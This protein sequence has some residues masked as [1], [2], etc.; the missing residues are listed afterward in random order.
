MSELIFSN[1]G[2]LTK[3]YNYEIYTKHPFTGESGWDIKFISVKADCK[4]EADKKIESYPN[5][6]C[7][8]LYNWK[9]YLSDNDDFVEFM[10]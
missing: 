6:D 9:H 10:E 4:K 5:F 3:Y 2:S 1:T 7:V 8:I